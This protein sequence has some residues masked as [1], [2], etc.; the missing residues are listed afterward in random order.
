MSRMPLSPAEATRLIHKKSRSRS[1]S[2]QITEHAT[3][4]LLERGLLV[5]DVLHL[6]KFGYVY[7]EGEPSTWE[8]FFKYKIDGTTPNSGGRMVRVVIIPLTMDAVKIV[9]AM[10]RDEESR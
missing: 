5:G 6:L 7:E 8:G 10:W 1:F 9:T 4:R 2:L 3:D